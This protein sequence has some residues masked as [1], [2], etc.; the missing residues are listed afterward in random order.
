[1]AARM[2]TMAQTTISPL[3]TTAIRQ[4]RTLRP[5]MSRVRQARTTLTLLTLHRQADCRLVNTMPAVLH[6]RTAPKDEAEKWRL[7]RLFRAD[8]I[9]KRECR[10]TPTICTSSTPAQDAGSGKCSRRRSRS[11]AR[12][13]LS[14]ARVRL[15]TTICKH[16]PLPSP[17]ALEAAQ[18]GPLRLPLPQPSNAKMQRE[19]AR[20]ARRRKTVRRSPAQAVR[21]LRIQSRPPL[22][23]NTSPRLSGTCCDQSISGRPLPLPRRRQHLPSQHAIHACQRRLTCLDPRTLST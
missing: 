4:T 16:P 10:G 13:T 7:Q 5:R 8:R 20:Q 9:A 1:M 18:N 6:P 11:E 3:T 19:K 17:P 22:P 23:R 2:D 15:P 14:S 21:P 12:L